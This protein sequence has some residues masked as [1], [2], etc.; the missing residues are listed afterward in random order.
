M[1]NALRES[2]SSFS[3]SWSRLREI[4][5]TPH[6]HLSSEESHDITSEVNSQV[7]R[8]GQLL[9]E[10]APDG[11]TFSTFRFEYPHWMRESSLELADD[12]T[13]D[14]KP[15]ILFDEDGDLIEVRRQRTNPKEG[16][17]IIEHAV[18]SNLEGNE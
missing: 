15:T 9:S 4:M 10:D 6:A 2:P 16:E 13:D 3:A 17:V 18:A 8:I 1:R 7:Q 11:H 12:S 5:A 14:H